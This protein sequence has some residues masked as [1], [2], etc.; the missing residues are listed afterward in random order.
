MIEGHGL[1]ATARFRL[2]GA[3]RELQRAR[4]RVFALPV[5][6]R[7]S[8]FTLGFDAA[9]QRVWVV[10]GQ[11]AVR[12]FSRLKTVAETR[13]GGVG[14]ALRLHLILPGSILVPIPTTAKRRRIRGLCRSRLSREMPRRSP[15]QRF[16]PHSSSDPAMRSAV[17]RAPRLAAHGR[18]ARHA[19]RRRKARCLIRRRLHDRP[20]LPARISRRGTGGRWTRRGCGGRRG[21]EDRT[22]V[23][24]VSEQ[25]TPADELFLQRAYE[26]AARGIGNT[27]PNSAGRRTHRS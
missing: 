19:G 23:E 21:D 8:G 25:L 5:R 26:L 10:R 7:A 14:V 11:L 6:R 2:S 20:G 17:A 9:R 4:Q 22:T 13:C 15:T 27:A 3:V 24:R 1:A 12:G 16:S 18:S